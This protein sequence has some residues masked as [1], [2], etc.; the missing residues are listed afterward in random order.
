MVFSAIIGLS[1]IFICVLKQTLKFHC[2]T[3]SENRFDIYFLKQLWNTL[4][5]GFITFYKLLITFYNWSIIR[6]FSEN[7][8]IYFVKYVFLIKILA[9][10]FNLLLK[11]TIT[12]W[13]FNIQFLMKTTTIPIRVFT[14]FF[15]KNYAFNLSMLLFKTKISHLIFVF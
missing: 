7:Y 11:F 2:T 13:N 15:L 4:E 14:S 9:C 10:D 1:V 3:I 12:F 8:Q 6:L 5:K